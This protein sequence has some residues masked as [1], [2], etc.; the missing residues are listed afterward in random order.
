[1]GNDRVFW[2]ILAALIASAWLFRYDLEATQT[3]PA[4]F[5]LDRWTGAVAICTMETCQ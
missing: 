1:M 2:V 3:H 4:A 5:R